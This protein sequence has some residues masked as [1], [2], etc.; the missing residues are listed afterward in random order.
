M[1]SRALAVGLA[2]TL[3]L[4]TAGVRAAEP[5]ASAGDARGR[6]RAR[7]AYDRGASAHQRGDH[8]TAARELALADSILPNPVTL[9]AALEE[10]LDA[11]D[12]VLA[13]EL[14][15]RAARGP[16]EP[17]LAA[18]TQ[19]ARAR[20]ARR[21][22]R[23]RVDCG[24]VACAVTLDGG[25]VEAGRGIVVRVGHHTLAVDRGGAI[26]QRTVDV[27]PEATASVVLGGP[28]AIEEAPKPQVAP[29]PARG[30]SPGWFIAALGATAVAGG[31]TFGFA[32]DTA[33]RHA[34]FVAAGC[35]GPV[36]GDCTGLAA[37]GTAAQL[38]TDVLAGVT[39][40][41]GVASV[42][43]GVLTFRDRRAE[44]ASIGLGAGRVAL[45]RVPLP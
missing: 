3:A 23:V 38:R 20:F 10:A 37:D 42:V 24:G 7:E 17:T 2:T 1:S 28:T 6:A 19:R 22:G 45:L 21:V 29:P 13:V 34:G 35:A 39:A 12:A 30:P 27:E 33:N 5:D 14:C 36:H 31:V 15:D 25:A 26:A 18:L 11:D 40:A 43:A 4:L 9:Q 8:A 32:V 44:R 16:V 41:L